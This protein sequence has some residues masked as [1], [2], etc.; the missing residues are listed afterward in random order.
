L[1]PAMDGCLASTQGSAFGNFHIL[2]SC[3]CNDH[4]LLYTCCGLQQVWPQKGPTRRL[5]PT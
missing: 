4:L 5:P 2:V 1:S 3:T